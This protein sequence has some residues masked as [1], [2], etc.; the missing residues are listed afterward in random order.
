MLQDIWYALRMLSRNPGFTLVAVLTIALGIGIN[1]TLFSI[2]DSVALKPLPISDPGRVL[3]LKRWFQNGSEG[4]IQYYFSYP[5]YVQLRDH[6][7]AFE[8]TV[9]SSLTTGVL[10]DGAETFQVQL[11]SSNYFAAL[12]VVAQIGRTFDA[13][14]D[15]GPGASP[16]LVLS[17]AF[18]Q[19]H[20]HGDPNVLGTTVHAG[21]AVLTV[22]GVAPETFTGT[23][24][25]LI[26]QVP[27]FWASL[28]MQGQLAPGRDW[29]NDPK[30]AEFQVLGKLKDS[31]P[32]A[33]AQAQIDSI[34][35]E[36]SQTYKEL[37]KTRAFTLER[38]ALFG[39]VDD[40][41][42][43]L[44]TGA[45][46]FAVGLVLLVAC[47][48]VANMLLALGAT[49]QR[50]IGVRIALGAGRM[51]IVRQLMT[52][53]IILAAS[54]GVVAI[55]FSAWFTRLLWNLLQEALA[56]SPFDGMTLRMNLNPDLRTFEYAFLASLVSAVL[57]GLVPSFQVAA[58]NVSFALKDGGGTRRSRL[59]SVLLGV[60]VFVSV[61]FLVVAGLLIRGL[62]RSEDATVG[63]DTSRI[64]VLQTDFG[65]DPAKSA[66]VQQRIL[67]QIGNLPEIRQAGFGT[68][69]LFGTW[70]PPI[71]VDGIRDRTLA[72]QASD[73]Y[74]DT[75][76]IDILRGRAFNRREASSGESVAIISESTARRFWPGQDPLLKHLKLDLRFTGQYTDFEI[77]GIA[78]DVRFANPTR[79][80]PVH[81][82]IATN[83]ASPNALLF[84]IQGDRQSALSAV[85]KSVETFDENLIPNL[86]L[87]N[88]EQGPLWV[89][90]TMPRML[91]LFL[92][93]LGLLALCL[94]GAGIYGVM[95][96]VIN[97]R[98]KEIGVRVAL[99]ADT[100]HV[101]RLVLLQ[102]LAP[103]I[104]GIVSGIAGALALS[105]VVHATI[106]FPGSSD[107]FHGVAFYD[108]VTVL[109]LSLFVAAVALF[110]SFG[111]ARRALG[112]DPIVTLRY[113]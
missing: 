110:A 40:I 89:H 33:L 100:G 11:V 99:G 103:V 5:E 18:W 75:L 91:T 66:A 53:S 59:R 54:G 86:K 27:D 56:G 32:P 19:R 9:A 67:Q 46:M 113:E 13:G 51:R 35:K 64:F 3:R 83:A 82:Y 45:L 47:A 48:N 98:V 34:L 80:D 23:N 69:P 61:I 41:R 104:A 22:I 28:S 24:A 62:V 106:S 77:V 92:G 4:D 14:E 30:D 29:L 68:A 37:Q 107:F 21:K 102:G 43:R 78:R 55:A 31:I 16:F 6:N 109:G 87:V 26:P 97:Q 84:R 10:S 112:V 7:A 88:L 20:F 42:F 58:A 73:S 72:S 49:R 38:P 95:S 50:E 101:L 85:R 12:G 93:V 90:K 105:W 15:R 1:T 25:Y 111:P 52:E 71:V 65:H 79:I 96:Y 8:N 70:T 108:P 60:Q 36:F 94:A 44:I 76:G 81:V 2:Y 63:Y 39:N 74:F 17:H 57:F